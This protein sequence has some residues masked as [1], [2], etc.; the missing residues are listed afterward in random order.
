[1]TVVAEFSINHTAFLDQHGKVISELPKFANDH[2]ALI[3]LYRW[4]VITRTFDT[5]AIALQRT[6]KL[7]T[8]ASPLGQEAIGVALGHA[9]AKDD[10]LCPAYREY[11]A[12]FQRGVKLADILLYWGGDERG[13]DFGNQSQDLPICVPIATQCL[14]AVGIAKAFQLRKQPRVSVSV[15]GD[16]GT[17]QGDFYEAIN[18]AGAWQL[19]TVFVINNNQWAISVPRKIQCGAATLAQKGIAAGIDSHQVDGNDVIACR[20]V[21]ANALEKART[22]KG[23]SLIEAITYRLCDHTTADDATRYTQ[24]EDLELAWTKEP[25][26]RMR[27][28][29]KTQKLWDDEK[30]QRLLK[31]ASDLV[32]D[33]VEQYLAVEPQPATAMFDFL[34]QELPDSYAD[35]YADLIED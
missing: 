33:E 29:L 15:I 30:E 35:Q 34:Y 9:M 24:K 3:E 7:G 1:M 32:A 11:G 22:G 8:Y 20:E 4:M 2:K 12:M 6:G 28:F 26:L 21:F 25:I 17:S 31:E 14:H 16:G 19:P 10:V 23:P 13:S 27:E 18:V 5:K